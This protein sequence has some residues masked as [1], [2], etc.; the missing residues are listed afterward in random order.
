MS[1]GAAFAVLSRPTKTHYYS[2]LA[3]VAGIANITA[4]PAPAWCASWGSVGQA[5]LDIRLDVL[6]GDTGLVVATSDPDGAL[7][8]SV[9]LNVT[10]GTYVVAVSAVGAAAGGYSDYG[11]LGAYTLT[12]AWPAAVLPPP[13][14]QR[15]PRKPGKS[16]PPT[17]PAPA[18]QQGGVNSTL[19]PRLVI[20]PG[21]TLCNV[22]GVSFYAWLRDRLQRKPPLYLDVTLRYTNV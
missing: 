10:A 12:A 7:D 22:Q 1:R 21:I 20:V 15:A 4:V 16:P 5:D 11:S 2:F 8:A 18:L 9:V 19:S 13:K 17:S 14:K 3:P 6:R